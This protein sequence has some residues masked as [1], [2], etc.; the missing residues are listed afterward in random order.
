MQSYSVEIIHTPERWQELST[1]WNDLLSKSASN[2]IFLTWEWLFSWAECYIN[3]NREIFILAVFDKEELLGIAPWYVN[4]QRE[5]YFLAYKQIEFLGTPE[6]ASDYLDVFVKKGK[7]KEVAN[8]IY[9]YLIREATS[10]WDCLAFKDVPVDS[11]FFFHF[12]NRMEEEGKYAEIGRGSICPVSSRPAGT[13]D[14]FLNISQH[15]RQR[16]SRELKLLNDGGIDYRSISSGADLSGALQEL[17]SFHERQKDFKDRQLY[18]LIEKFAARCRDGSVEIDLLSHQGKNIAGLLHL[19]H[20]DTLSLYLM[21]T[22][23]GFNPKISIGNVLVGL[24]I[25]RAFEREFSTYDFLK[26]SEP[27][28]FSWANGMRSSINIFVYGKKIIPLF[29]V[30]KRFLKYTAKIVLR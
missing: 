10:S 6:S 9:D 25:K 17:F 13:G 19:R 28:K 22:D 20:Q 15:R 7:E 26:G 2:T 3:A 23:K 29:I 1:Q 27:Y 16:F 11:P 18:R 30:A 14:F 24:S 8:R 4:H 12:M 21:A 5:Y